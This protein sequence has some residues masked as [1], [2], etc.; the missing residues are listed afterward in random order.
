[1]RLNLKVIPMPHRSFRGESC[2]LLSMLYR[3]L[4][5]NV[6][7]HQD[8]KPQNILVVSNERTSP[9]EWQFKLGDLGLSQFE[10]FASLKHGAAIDAQGTRTYG[11]C[12]S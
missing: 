10:K 7:L 12:V 2:T 8:V 6:R 11:E 4:T 5:A 3:I 1:M 9:H